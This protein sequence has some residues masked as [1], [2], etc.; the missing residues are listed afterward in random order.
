MN[1]GNPNMNHQEDLALE[2]MCLSL[3]QQRSTIQAKVRATEE[4]LNRK[5]GA[6]LLETSGHPAQSNSSAWRPS[7]PLQPRLELRSLLEQQISNVRSK[8]SVTERFLDGN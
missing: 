3:E 1:S 5:R 6:E 4:L 2:D 8:I 7:S